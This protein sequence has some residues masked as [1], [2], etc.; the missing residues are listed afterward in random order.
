MFR[1]T[2]IKLQDSSFIDK[3]VL[4]IDLAINDIVKFKISNYEHESNG[5][6]CF[7]GRVKE[8]DLINNSIAFDVSTKFNAEIKTFNINSIKELSII[9]NLINNLE[10]DYLMNK[11]SDMPKKKHR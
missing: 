10:E 7:E 5:S 2:S 11:I 1:V 8:I 3:Q 9:N 4:T 6:N